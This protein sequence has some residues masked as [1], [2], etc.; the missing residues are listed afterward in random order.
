MTEDMDSDLASDSQWRTGPPILGEKNTFRVDD[1]LTMPNDEQWCRRWRYG[2]PLINMTCGTDTYV[3]TQN[4]VKVTRAWNDAHTVCKY[5]Q[6]TVNLIIQ[7]LWLRQVRVTVRVSSMW[8]S[9]SISVRFGVFFAKNGVKD[10][11]HLISQQK[12]SK[13]RFRVYPTA[14]NTGY[15]MQ[16]YTPKRRIWHTSEKNG[17]LKQICPIGNCELPGE[18]RWP[19]CGGEVTSHKSCPWFVQTNLLST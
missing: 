9:K 17:H 6:C 12:G 14:T 11:L 15:I 10:D 8:H 4:S 16:W 18:N 2:S 3:D 1:W 13:A 7:N 5:V 19:L